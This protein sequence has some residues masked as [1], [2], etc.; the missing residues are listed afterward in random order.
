MK[1]YIQQIHVNHSCEVQEVRSGPHLARIYCCFC[2]KH[3]QWA[4][5]YEYRYFKNHIKKPMI[6]SNLKTQLHFN[7][8]RSLHET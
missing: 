4:K 3:V 1:S 8:Y 6:L 2:K 7:S 5:D